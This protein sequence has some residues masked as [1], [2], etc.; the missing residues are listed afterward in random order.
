[1]SQKDYF[2]LLNQPQ[3]FAVDLSSLEAVKNVLLQRLHPDRFVTASAL[4]KR[5]AQ[6]MSVQVNEAYRTLADDLLRAQ[7]LCK[8]KGFDVNEH[9][10]MPA[11]FCS[12]TRRW[13]RVS[14]RAMRAR[15]KGFLKRLKSTSAY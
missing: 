10:P 1:M 5:I 6:Q 12:G 7:Y 15:V 8:L 3:T 2:S 11:D 9:R 13:K 4:E 14:K